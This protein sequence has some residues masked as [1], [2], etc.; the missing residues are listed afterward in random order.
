M[1]INK[2]AIIEDVFADI[3]SVDSKNYFKKWIASPNLKQLKRFQ[4]GKETLM[5]VLSYTGYKLTYFS[6]DKFYKKFKGNLPDNINGE[7]TL[8]YNVEDLCRKFGI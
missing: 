3:E 4:F 6:D 1:F 7:V 8:F 5:V 2:E